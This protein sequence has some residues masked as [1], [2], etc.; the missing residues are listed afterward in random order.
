MDAVILAAGMGSRI[1]NL[2]TL[3]KGFI[4]IGHGTLIEQ[5]IKILNHYGI[6]NIYIIIGYQA[7]YYE[8]L[9]SIYN[10]LQCIYNENYQTCGSLLSWQYV[11]GHV[12]DNFLLLESDILYSEDYIREILSQEKEN[13]LL[14]TDDVKTH[15]AVF[16]ETKNNYLVNMN[17]NSSKL[18]HSDG[19][20]TGICKINLNSFKYLM[21]NFLDENLIRFGHYETDGLVYLTKHHPIYCHKILNAASCEID[22]YIHLEQA[23]KIYSKIRRNSSIFN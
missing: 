12:K 13:C 8:N 4:E 1:R 14:M 3:P 18:S 15:D 9:C 7:Q 19:E 16:I 17:K 23:Q 10:N 21:D 22:D 6:K 2:H 20:L 11:Y 5:S